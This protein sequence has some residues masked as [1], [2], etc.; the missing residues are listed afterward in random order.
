[1]DNGVT[2]R[3]ELGVGIDLVSVARIERMVDRWGTKF[4]KRVF[5]DGEIAYS[6]S[7]ARPGLSLAARFAAKEA[8]FKAVSPRNIGGIGFKH[9]EVVIGENGNPELVAHGPARQA[10]AAERA[11]LS[12]S[13]D[14]ELAV[15]IVVTSPEVKA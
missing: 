8:F 13:H 11:A 9:I 4:L 14:R 10:L 15:A 7:K 6:T 1:M 3:P 12:I 5:T 2:N